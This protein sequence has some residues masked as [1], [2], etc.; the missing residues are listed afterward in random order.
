MEADARFGVLTAV[1]LAVM[2]ANLGLWPTAEA[3]GWGKLGLQVALLSGFG[4]LTTAAATA[5]RRVRRAMRAYYYLY[6]VVAAAL[7]F[8]SISIYVFGLK[9]LFPRPPGAL[10]QF[11]S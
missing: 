9:P 5:S 2:L 6:V 7:I 8:I 10:W 4:A 11:S 1:Y 3:L